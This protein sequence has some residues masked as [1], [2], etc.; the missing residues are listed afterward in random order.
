PVGS[1]LGLAIVKEL[2]VAMGGS[3]EATSADGGGAEFLVR[4]PRGALAAGTTD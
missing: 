2:V 1:G 3:V 4:L